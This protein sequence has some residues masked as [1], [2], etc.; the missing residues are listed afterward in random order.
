MLV[1]WSELFLPSGWPSSHATNNISA[2]KALHVHFMSSNKTSLTLHTTVMSMKTIYSLL[3]RCRTVQIGSFVFTAGC[4][5]GWT[6]CENLRP[7]ILQCC[8]DTVGWVRATASHMFKQL[9]T[10]PF[11]IK[12]ADNRPTQVHIEN[13]R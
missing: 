1:C 6:S 5:A 13:G 9:A 4:V 10:T 12:G 11:T 3:Y 7:L 8:F 2:L